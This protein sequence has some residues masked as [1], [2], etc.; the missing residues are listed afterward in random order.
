MVSIFHTREKLDPKVIWRDGE[1][2]DDPGFDVLPI[3]S[4]SSFHLDGLKRDT[5]WMGQTRPEQ[6]S[7]LKIFPQSCS[8]EITWNLSF[9][10]GWSGL[11][12]CGHSDGIWMLLCSRFRSEL[13]VC[14]AGEG[15]PLY[16]IPNAYLCRG[17]GVPMAGRWG[18]EYGAVADSGHAAP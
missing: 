14:P 7:L 11:V 9:R 16:P 5:A 6:G 15:P 2:S 18:W 12:W 17:L 4:P 10:L 1:L 8:S 3:S 13:D